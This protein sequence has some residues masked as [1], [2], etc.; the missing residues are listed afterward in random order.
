MP[1]KKRNNGQCGG[2]GGN[3]PPEEKVT[4]KIVFNN[5]HEKFIDDVEAFG[6]VKNSNV[7]YYEKDGKIGYIPGMAVKYFGRKEIYD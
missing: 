2:N 6:V 5:D 3:K 1:M 4:L 7:F